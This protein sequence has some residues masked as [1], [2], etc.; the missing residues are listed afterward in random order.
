MRDTSAVFR[1]EGWN[2][3]RIFFLRNEISNPVFEL[4]NKSVIPKYRMKWFRFVNNLIILYWKRFL[5]TS[6]R[7]KRKKERKKTRKNRSLDSWFCVITLISISSWIGEGKTTKMRRTKM[8]SRSTINKT[9]FP[10][11]DVTDCKK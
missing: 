3:L 11:I 4:V 8:T 5:K 9:M 10:L 6:I 2:L 7:R 1:S